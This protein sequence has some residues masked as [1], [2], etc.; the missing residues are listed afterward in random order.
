MRAWLNPG[1]PAAGPSRGN[2]WL[3]GRAGG[4]HLPGGVRLPGRRIGSTALPI[5][6]QPQRPNAQ[7]WRRALALV[8]SNPSPDILSSVARR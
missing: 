1:S 4:P 6:V 2:L 8:V 5:W 7:P 3:S